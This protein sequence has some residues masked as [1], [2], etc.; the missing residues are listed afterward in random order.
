MTTATS[1]YKLVEVGLF[2]NAA[3]AIDQ[4]EN[5]SRDLRVLRARLEN[6]VGV[7][8]RAKEAA[9]QLLRE[10]LSGKERATC[11]EVIGRITLCRGQIA[12]GLRAMNQAFVAAT[13]CQDSQFEARLTAS[14]IES[15]LHW[16]GLEPATLEMPKL[17]QAA[18]RSGDA[19]LMVELHSLDAEIKAKRGLVS[20]ALASVAA[21]RS[22][23]DRYENIAQQGRLAIIAS[24]IAII[25]SDYDTALQYAHD[26]LNCANRSGSRELRIPT[27]NNLAYIRLAQQAYAE[28]RLYLDELLVAVPKGGSTEIGVRDT[29]MMLA[30]ACD[31]LEAA[32]TLAGQIA[33]IASNQESRDSY[34][35]LWHLPTRIKWLYRV[36]E[37]SHGLEVA[38]EAIPKVERK[39]DR[40]LL[41]RL[42]LLAAEGLGRTG[43]AYEGATLMATA[44]NANPDPSI[45][46]MAEGFRVAGRLISDENPVAALEH[47]NQ[48]RRLLEGIGNPTAR[49]E[50]DRDVGDTL[51]IDATT[52]LIANPLFCSNHRTP[53]ATFAER[54]GA[55]IEIGSN[56]RVLA[57]ELFSLVVETNAVL[58]A[59]I[60]EE[61]AA[62]REL[63]TTYSAEKLPSS[64]DEHPDS[65]RFI[66]GSHRSRQYEIVALPRPTP[67]ARATLMWVQRLLHASLAIARGR[68]LERERAALWPE[69]TPEQQLGLICASDQMRELIK[70]I[71]RV[72]A[73][74]VSVLLTGE[75]GVGKELFARA[76]HQASSRH[77]KVL[78]PFNCATVPREMF[79][80]QLFGH[81]RGSF[82]GATDDSPGVIRAAAGGTLFLDEI[83]EMSVD[84]QPKLLRFLESGEIRPLG[85]PR[86]QFV[87]VR[88]VA[89]TNA[90]LDQL[91]AQGRFREDLYYRLN[92][93]RID[94]PPLRERRE[95][96]PALVGHFLDAYGREL[97]KPQLRVANETLEYL[98]LYRWPGNVRQLANEVR[99]MVALA[100]PGAVLM[101]AHLSN[102]ISMSRKT[103]PAERPALQSTEVVTRLDQP[104]A[105]AVEHIE[106]AAIQRAVSLAEGNLIEAAR[107][108]G[109]SRKGLYLK[110]QR[111]GLE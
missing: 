93:I 5:V 87:D 24:G 21:A 6:H 85:D 61:H 44:I 27:L 19:H 107:M 50:V 67:A 10:G 12:D 3:R 55:I 92:V 62:G 57:N 104:L 52:K 78:L 49:A 14:Y 64:V 38:L 90:N 47:Y 106:R 103:I 98:V 32:T 60:V 83:G 25:Q 51:P 76:L 70:N 65:V 84:A 18:M 58:Q 105:A 17:R 36:G 63:S 9:Q 82:T 56:P 46:L 8:H 43:R 42:R 48:A 33:E 40:N 74:N 79:D 80:S 94:I 111:L 54:I 39:T 75:T 15:L 69:Q 99:R 73:T 53:A 88:I 95:E 91:V 109:L 66:L 102:D 7:P 68:Q 31:D 1:A 20:G 72:A 37:A 86:P 30:L 59:A 16:V 45:E 22:L 26:A 11:W 35:E 29:E 110:R 101:P 23:L 89:A 100:E 108:L 13:S 96:I 41:Q 81:R 71:R 2:K 28:V 4:S 77:D 34:Y 97:Q